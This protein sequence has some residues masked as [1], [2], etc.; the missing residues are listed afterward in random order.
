MNEKLIAAKNHVHRNRAKYAVAATLTAC[1]AVQYKAA[2]QWN[3]FLKEND[4]FEKFYQ[5][6]D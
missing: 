6:Q 4:L 5:E 2:T 1:V 3:N